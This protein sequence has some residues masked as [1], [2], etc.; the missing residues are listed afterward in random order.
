MYWFNPNLIDLIQPVSAVTVSFQEFSFYCLLNEMHWMVRFILHSN[1]IK[2]RSLSPFE[3]LEISFLSLKGVGPAWTGDWPWP[4]ERQDQWPWYG[5]SLQV[6][7]FCW[8]PMDRNYR[9]EE[10]EQGFFTGARM[11]I[12]VESEYLEATTITI[13]L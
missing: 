6:K 3:H 2:I 7:K 11:I 1:L 13:R 8:K 5:C 4:L 9:L 10:G 12:S